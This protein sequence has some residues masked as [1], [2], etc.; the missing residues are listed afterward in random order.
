MNELTPARIKVIGVG[1]G[2]GNAVSQMVDT[3]IGCAEFFAVN[4]DVQDLHKSLVPENNRI[5]IGADQTKGYGAGANPEKGRLSAEDDLDAIKS[6]IQGA[7]ML[8]IAAGMG[9]GT[10]TGAAPVIAKAAREQGILTVGVVT[11]PFGFEGKRRMEYAIEGVENLKEHVDSIIVI[12]NDK[13]LREMPSLTVKSAFTA[14][15]E[16]LGDAI[17]G[18]SEV[19]EEN[20]LIN[21]DFADI[22]T[23]MSNSGIAMMGRGKGTGS[24]RALS[25][26]RNAIDSPLLE[27]ID[28]KNASGLIVSICGGFDVTLEE[29]E[30]IGQ[31]VQKIAGKDAHCII[32][33]SLDANISGDL[34][35]TVIAT[36]LNAKEEVQQQ[37]LTPTSSLAA[38]H[39]TQPKPVQQKK[40]SV[41][42]F[43]RRNSNA[44]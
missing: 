32:G 13:L 28:I 11:K 14:V 1:G 9:G 25:A 8:F 18:V 3:E 36:G 35:V 21:I 22:N 7:D 15:N 30:L 20:G 43:L 34:M 38:N 24:D 31:E 6:T 16:V 17:K 10:G 39:A 19:I 44:S 26:V 12:P 5:A 40:A 42:S 33:N 29:V 27:D 2:G 23:V 4:T 41:P 37:T